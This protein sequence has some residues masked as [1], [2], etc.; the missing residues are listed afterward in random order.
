MSFDV[1]MQFFAVVECS[2]AADNVLAFFHILHRM[3]TETRRRQCAVQFVQLQCSVEL[4]SAFCIHQTRNDAGLLQ[5]VVFML[6]Y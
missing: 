6:K 5:S 1:V 3:H 4:G 2:T